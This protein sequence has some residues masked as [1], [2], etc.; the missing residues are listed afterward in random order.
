MDGRVI[1]IG[2]E[3]SEVSHKFT[4]DYMIVHVHIYTHVDLS[5]HL[6]S[7]LW[8]SPL[9]QCGSCHYACAKLGHTLNLH[10]YLMCHI[11]ALHIWTSVVKPLRT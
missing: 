7:G 4:T 8:M 1:C 2:E 10:E 5:S 6:V 9:S 3:G 11:I